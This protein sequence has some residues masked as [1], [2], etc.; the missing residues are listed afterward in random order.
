MQDGMESHAE[1]RRHR[2]A[3]NGCENP[4]HARGAAAAKTLDR[5][6]ALRLGAF[7]LAHGFGIEAAKVSIVPLEGVAVDRDCPAMQPDIDDLPGRL[8]RLRGE[9]WILSLLR[10]QSRE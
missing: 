8:L 9:R 2:R 5:R 7:R 6:S 4:P 1:Q 10:S 3:A